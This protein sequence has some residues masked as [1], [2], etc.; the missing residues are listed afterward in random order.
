MWNGLNWV[1]VEYSDRFCVQDFELWGLIMRINN[2]LKPHNKLL[3][4]SNMQTIQYGWH[5][6]FND[7]SIILKLCRIGWRMLLWLSAEFWKAEVPPIL[8]IIIALYW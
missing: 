1:R 6:L 7:T 3:T 4:I 5:E 2:G 8:D